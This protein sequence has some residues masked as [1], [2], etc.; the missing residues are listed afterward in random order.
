MARRRDAP[1]A[2]ERIV[3]AVRGVALQAR[4]G[5]RIL[6][7]AVAFLTAEIC[8]LETAALDAVDAHPPARTTR[9]AAPSCV[10]WARAGVDVLLRVALAAAEIA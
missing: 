9:N 5:S 1:I 6:I 2:A 10:A 4:P 8:G 3:A 7:P